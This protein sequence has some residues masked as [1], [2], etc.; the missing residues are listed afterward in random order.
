MSIQILPYDQEHIQKVKEFNSRLN[1][2]DAGFVFPETFKSEEFPAAG[3][4]RPVELAYYVVRDSESGDIHGGYILKSYSIWKQGSELVIGNYQ[5][6]L[7]EGIVNPKFSMVGVQIY[8]H[9]IR[10]Q[11]KLYSLGMGSIER[12]L[13]QFLL[14]MKWIVEGVPFYFKILNPSKVIKNLP[15][16]RNHSK[17]RPFIFVLDQL[18]FFSIGMNLLNFL[19]KLKTPAS[20]TSAEV[21]NEFGSWAD[22]IWDESKSHYQWIGNRNAATLN[23]LYPKG[24]K[25]YIRLHVKE[26]GNSIGW[27]LV[28]ATVMKDHKQFPN[29]TVGTIVDTLSLAGYEFMVSQ[30]AE[31]FLKEKNVDLIVSNQSHHL[32]GSALKRLGFFQGPTNYIAAFSPDMWKG[33]ESYSECHI[34][35]G[36]G[37]GPINL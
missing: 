36:D 37:D 21:V 26:N 11:S 12:A 6:P 34:N 32:W 28:L 8:L 10:S 23:T 22:R 9:A 29:L 27:A 16:I 31:Q 35:R 25:C 1:R 19:N 14:K 7:S 18:K 33:L 20:K 4:G 17:L 5:L 2:G 30:A 13:P 24:S 3:S 15:A